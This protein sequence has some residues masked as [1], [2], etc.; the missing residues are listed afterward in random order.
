M[1]TG[2][3]TQRHCCDLFLDLAILVGDSLRHDFQKMTPFRDKVS[4]VDIPVSIRSQMIELP[5]CRSLTVPAFLR[6]TV[7]AE[8]HELKASAS[9]NP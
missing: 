2:L 7:V 4:E 9:N 5:C 1:E 3:V 6:A 8:R